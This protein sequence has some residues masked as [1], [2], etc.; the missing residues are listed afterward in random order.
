MD[1][2]NSKMTQKFQDIDAIMGTYGYYLKTYVDM[3]GD[4]DA[5]A[6][7]LD[8]K[9]KEAIKKEKELGSDAQT[10]VKKMEKS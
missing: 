1:F 9:Q 7:L 5:F 10:K 4:N 8:E 3:K 2:L 6:K